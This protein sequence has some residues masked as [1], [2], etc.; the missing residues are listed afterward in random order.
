MAERFNRLIY[1]ALAK[2]LITHSKA[3]EMMDV[4]L[5]EMKAIVRSWRFQE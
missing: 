5:A 1:T 4:T 2:E 3:A